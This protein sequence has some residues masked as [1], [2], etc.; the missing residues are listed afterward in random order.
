MMVTPGAKHILR[1]ILLFLAMVLIPGTVESREIQDMLGRK[2]IVPENI[3]KVYSASPPVTHMI[4]AV[5]PGLL[6]ALYSPFTE[7]QKKCLR[8]NLSDL[9]VIGGSFGQGQASNI[10]AVLRHKPDIVVTWARE[11]KIPLQNEQVE[12]IMQ[13]A[14]IPVLYLLMDN[15]ADYP[16]TFSFLGKL[17]KKEER[18]ALLG[19]YGKDTF[20]TVR[21]IVA[22][23]PSNKKQKVYYAEGSDG[24]NTECVDS[25]HAELIV[26][27]GGLNVHRCKQ[28]SSGGMEKV[29]LEQVILYDPDVII[30]RE[31]LF[32][33][34]VFRDQRWSG[35]QAVKGKR[36]YLI[37]HL[38][39]NWF[40]RPPSFM[41]FLGL[42]W[43]TNIL[44]PHLYRIN[45]AKE[46]REFFKLFLGVDLSEEEI[47]EVLN[48]RY[49][50]TAGAK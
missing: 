21:K 43:L 18:T 31:K 49:N 38:P 4:Y 8:N 30:T 44:Y 5:D 50:R 26:L 32:Y 39:F 14:G 7:D 10:E 42:K 13:K 25:W 29:S 19:R 46:T 1:G 15:V 22:G 24:L 48:L 34:R 36:V 2:V 16:D 28:K 45:M 41:R 37:P 47:G 33:D 40:D 12:K 27:A 9:P 17:F 20:L 23:I 6:M 3:R 11:K 35:I